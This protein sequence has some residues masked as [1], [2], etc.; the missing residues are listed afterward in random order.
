MR[1]TFRE[2][3]FY[4]YLSSKES[5]LL[6]YGQESG[7]FLVRLSK[8][9]PGAFA[10]AFVY[11]PTQVVHILIASDQPNGYTIVDQETATE[12]KFKD[13]QSIF[14]SFKEVLIHPFICNIPRQR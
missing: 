3:W 2:P 7:T 4:G 5:E 10:L 1:K 14:D 11:E 6:L 13:F 8:S 9:A 12:T